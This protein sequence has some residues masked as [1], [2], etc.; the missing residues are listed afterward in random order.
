MMLKQLERDIYERI[1]KG[2][3]VQEHAP[4]RYKELKKELKQ[5]ELERQDMLHIIELRDDLTEEQHLDVMIKM[6]DILTRRRKTKDEI[7]YYKA[8]VD[9]V[10]NEQR[11]NYKK[12]RE[13]LAEV[14]VVIDERVYYLKKRTDLTEYLGG[15][16]Q[17]RNVN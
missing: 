17:L 12:I 14:S 5:N 10:K 13:V 7:L 16:I 2:N 3:P 1:N 11:I 6:K 8:L 9:L 4:E 15:D